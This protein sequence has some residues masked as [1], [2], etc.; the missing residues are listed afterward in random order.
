[1][2]SSSPFLRVKHYGE[3]LASPLPSPRH[4]LFLKCIQLKL[5]HSLSV[6]NSP[7]IT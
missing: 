4:S 6:T 3:R 1:M 2:N 7:K 5:G